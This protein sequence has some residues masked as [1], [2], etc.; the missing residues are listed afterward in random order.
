MANLLDFEMC[1]ECG[2]QEAMFHGVCEDCRDIEL[3]G[4]TSRRIIDMHDTYSLCSHED[5]PCC[6]C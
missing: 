2:E 1:A 5:R 3:D 6:G 4:M